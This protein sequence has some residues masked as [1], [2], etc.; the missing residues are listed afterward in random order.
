V[1]LVDT[2]AS[3]EVLRDTDSSA[4]DAVDRLIADKVAICDPVSMEVLAG[5][6]DEHHLA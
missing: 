2:S 6:R 5:A 4:C 3:I 1:I